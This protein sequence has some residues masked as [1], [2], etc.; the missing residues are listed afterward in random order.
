MLEW[1]IP[2]AEDEDWIN[3][4]IAVS[5]TMASD[6]SFANIYLLRNKYST[7]ISRYKD[8]IIRKYSGK[9]ARCGYTFPLGKG[10]VAKALAEIEKDAKECGERL[11]F[12]FVTEEQKEVLENAMPARFC[13]S[14]DAGDSDYIYLRSELAS[15]SGKAFH[16]KK[17]HFSKFVRTYPDYK[18]YEIGACNIYD[19]QK[20]ADAW[21]YEHLQDED[22]S[23]LAEYKAIKEALENFEELGLIGGII[24]VNDSPCAMTIASKINENTVDVHFE[25]AVGEYALNGGYAAINKLFSEKL[26]GVTWLNREEDIGIEGLRKAKLSYRPKIMLKKYSAVEK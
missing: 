6:A 4:C 11:Q 17:N 20:V 15:L 16:K 10:D 14:S 9:G 18:Y 5:G 24:Y 22:A 26:D 23:Q 21:Y 25:K 12:A 19:A 1:S 13:Y 2:E 3:S 7:K 8:F